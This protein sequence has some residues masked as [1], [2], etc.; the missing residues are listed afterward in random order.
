[1]QIIK[2]TYLKR[3]FSVKV[4]NDIYEEIIENNL[5]LYAQCTNFAKDTFTILVKGFDTMRLT[6]LIYGNSKR[7]RI[8]FKNGDMFDFRRENMEIL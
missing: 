1:M 5:K 2:V 6:T 3:E 4:D 8:H 7:K